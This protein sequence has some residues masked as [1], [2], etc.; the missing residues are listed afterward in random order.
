MLRKHKQRSVVL[1][2]IDCLSIYQRYTFW[3]FW[4]F[5][6][7]WHIIRCL[8]MARSFARSQVKWEDEKKRDKRIEMK[9]HWDT[10][11]W[12][13]S[14]ENWRQIRQ[15]RQNISIRRLI[16]IGYLGD[17]DDEST[18]IEKEFDWMFFF[19]L[20]HFVTVASGNT[21]QQWK[22]KSFEWKYIY[23]AKPIRRK[24]IFSFNVCWYRFLLECTH[25]RKC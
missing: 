25:T 16:H 8:A 13:L 18:Y 5:N 11:N 6:N 24:V 22:K 3:F 4:H 23:A 2:I 20:F 12:V 10:M 19:C 9:I 17:D 21:F 1:C 7:R 14:M 15:I